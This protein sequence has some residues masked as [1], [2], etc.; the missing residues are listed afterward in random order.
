MLREILEVSEA[1]GMSYHICGNC[2]VLIRTV[3]INTAIKYQTPFVIYGS[4]SI[5][6]NVKAPFKGRVGFFHC[7]KNRWREFP[8]IVF[9]LAK[10]C[11][12]SVRQRIQMQVP[13]PQRYRPFVQIPFPKNTP[14]FLHFFQYIKWDTMNKV[15]LLQREL[16]WSYPAERK[17]RFDCLVHCFGNFKDFFST[18]VTADG[19]IMSSMVR[20][21]RM[22]KE[23]FFTAER[24]L[25]ES[26]E[27]ECQYIVKKVGLNN[28]KMPRIKYTSI[29]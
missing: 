23:E 28:Y 25:V 2:E 15:E 3:A 20:D 4:S 5:E 24:E 6:D 19:F 8:K 22:N 12:L 21:N 1:L 29:K 13:G 16:N 26:L 9:H 10:Y 18:G 7:L 14:I 27:E 11:F 17:S